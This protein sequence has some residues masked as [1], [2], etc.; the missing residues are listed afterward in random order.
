MHQLNFNWACDMSM[1]K[2][3]YRISYLLICG[4]ISQV[5]EVTTKQELLYLNLRKR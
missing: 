2:E 4:T 1:V 5:A 3:S